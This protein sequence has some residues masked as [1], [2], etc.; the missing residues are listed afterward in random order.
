MSDS[1]KKSKRGAIL[2]FVLALISFISVLC[3]R[4]MDETVQEL[5]HV[6]QH[7]RRDDLRVSAYSALDLAVG[8][9]NEF[10]SI[11][12]GLHNWSAKYWKDPLSYVEE[13]LRLDTS[14]AWEFSQIL[15]E[16][17]K[18]SLQNAPKKFFISM[19]ARMH[20]KSGSQVDEDDG[21]PYWDAW[22]DWEDADDDEREE[23][24]EDNYYEKF[25]PPYFTPSKKVKSFEEFRMIKGFSYDEQLAAYGS[26]K[27]GLFFSENGSENINMKNFRDSF[28]FYND[29]PVN[30]FGLSNF[31]RKLMSG[32]DD[33]LYEDLVE[34]PSLEN[35]NRLV[36]ILNT[37]GIKH[38]DKATLLRVIVTVKRGK[39]RFKLQAILSSESSLNSRAAKTSAKSTQKKARPRS[40]TNVSLQYPFRILSIR[41]NENFI[42]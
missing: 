29:G 11:D 6:S 24:A 9:I 27:E 41:E 1:H 15:D 37:L 35:E 13:D 26:D 42:D 31:L 34:G 18:I 12:K 21:V 8:V 20:N 36:R 23:G 17:G 3:V 7:H 16:S 32:D 39:A 40:K 14:Y 4:L 19:F 2:V 25:D 22:M 10:K 5:R 30:R 28:S 38:D 33:S